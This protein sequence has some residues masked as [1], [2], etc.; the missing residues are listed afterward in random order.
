[1]EEKDNPTPE[2]EDL[3]SVEKEAWEAAAQTVAAMS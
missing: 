1:M 2:W 3:S